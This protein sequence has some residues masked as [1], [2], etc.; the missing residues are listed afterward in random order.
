MFNLL[1]VLNKWDIKFFTTSYYLY[2]VSRKFT[3]H[4]LKI[5][6]FFSQN[7]KPLRAWNMSKLISIKWI[8]LY[9]VR[10]KHILPQICVCCHYYGKYLYVTI[11]LN[12]EMIMVLI[13]ALESFYLLNIENHKYRIQH[14]KIKSFS[15]LCHDKKYLDKVFW[16]QNLLNLG[17]L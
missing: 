14:W 5:H 11:L 2:I 15:S 13:S 1:K 10:F 6:D 7:F 3:S 12:S 9:S 4:A 17:K 16:Q 8:I